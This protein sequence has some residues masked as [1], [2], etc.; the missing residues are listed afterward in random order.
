MKKSILSMMAAVPLA[1]GL[2][3]QTETNV[4]AAEPELAAESAILVDAD[5]GQILYSKKP[6]VIL[7]P[8]S[9]TKMMT[10]YLVNEAVAQGDTSWD[11]EVNVTSKAEEISQ[12]NALSNVPLRQ[13]RTYT[14]QELY[15]AMA[16][17]S[18][19]GASIA[20]AEHVA[21]SESD[22][23]DMMNSKAEE[24]G[25]E[26]Y[27]FV[28]STGLNNSS[29]DGLH[30]EGTEPDAENMMSA[31]ASAKLAYHLLDEYPDV[32][33]TASITEKT[34]RENGANTSMDNWNWMLPGSMYG[35]LDYEGVDGLKT[36]YTEMAGNAFTGTVEQNGTRFISVVMRTDSQTAR[37][38][39]T[40]K[41]Y[42]YGFENLSE[43]EIVQEGQSFEDTSSIPVVNGKEDTVSAST[44]S[45]L[46]LLL[47]NGAAE[48]IS[49]S[50]EINQDILNEDG[51]LEAP[52]EAG[53]EIGQVSLTGEAAPQ[54]LLEQN[55]S[56]KNVPLVID[57]GVE[58]SGWFA[59]TM[60]SVGG[61]FGSMWSGASSFVQGLF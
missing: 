34:F 10:E 59:L 30:P 32:L 47:E 40:A 24:L 15:E 28:N 14:V 3:F 51:E 21:G 55:A 8:A 41:L 22:F 11:A 52:V 53:T 54:Y 17:Y 57:E 4:Q 50:V 23:V 5:S 27:E 36:G 13:N 2:L 12:N 38:K 60:K 37:F 9:M 35:S 49:T 19:N 39:E 61:F 56:S 48:N 1:A 31:R 46:S 33:D 25:M 44:G 42:N 18:A 6:D 43:T 20:L 29:M 26:E 45:S 7:P 16:I 58:R